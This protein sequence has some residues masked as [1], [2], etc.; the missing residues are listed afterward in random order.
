MSDRASRL[1]LLWWWWWWQW[2]LTGQGEEV[3]DL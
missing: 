1:V 3:I 2:L